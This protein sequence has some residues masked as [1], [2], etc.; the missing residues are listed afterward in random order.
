MA[1]NLNSLLKTV[2][3]NNA[4]GLHIRGN[5]IAYVRMNGKMRAIENCF[6]TNDEVKQIAGAI[7]GER[8][9][10][11]FERNLSVDF[12]LDAKEHGRFRFNVFRQSGKIC[13]KCQ[14]GAG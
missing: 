6:L 7:M 8:E 11:L 10:K 1:V 2:V 12:A 4:T 14:S 3:D 9:K 5:S 13:R